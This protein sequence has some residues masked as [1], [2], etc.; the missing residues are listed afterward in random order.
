MSI[1]HDYVL[2]EGKRGIDDPRN[3]FKAGMGITKGLYGA[4]GAGIGAKIGGSIGKAI[5]KRKAKNAASEEEKQAI[6]KKYKRRGALAGAGLG[7]VGGVAAVNASIKHQ[8]GT[9]NFYK[10]WK[11][12]AGL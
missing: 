3:I 6:I 11:K 7:G 12:K 4:A 10:D 8:G 2:N 5:G 9:K 1:L